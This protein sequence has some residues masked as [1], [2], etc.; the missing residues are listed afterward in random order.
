MFRALSSRAERLLVADERCLI[1]LY[2]NVVP[3]PQALFET[4]RASAVWSREVDDFGEQD[5]ET[6]YV[7]DEG[8]TFAFVGL[9]LRPRPWTPAVRALR[10]ELE[11]LLAPRVGALIGGSAAPL[12]LSGCLMNRY[13]AN[14]GFIPWHSDEVRAHGPSR[15]VCAV[16]LGGPRRF[17]V[18]AKPAATGG[19]P[20]PPVLHDVALPSGSALLMAGDAQA[21]YEHAL[22]LDVG[23]APA[24]ISLTF[25]SI[26]PGFEE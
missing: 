16:S 26:V 12:Q 20:D 15:V 13:D 17:L 11:G 14:A 21:R 10:R 7:G 19:D 5:R 2:E 18:R 3:N 24:R 1:A 22:P 9:T 4:V 6:C 8:C 23:A 25:R